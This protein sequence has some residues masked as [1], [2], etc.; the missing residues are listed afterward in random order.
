M[1][2]PKATKRAGTSSQPSLKASF[3]AVRNAKGAVS[4]RKK[5]ET[6]TPI[7]TDVVATPPVKEAVP[8][9]AP[10]KSL[11]KRHSTTDEDSEEEEDYEPISPTLDLDGD[12]KSGDDVVEVSISSWTVE[13]AS[14]KYKSMSPGHDPRREAPIGW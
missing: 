2:P 11:K 10:K 9:A 3:A 1:P 6:V 5:V 12:G 8:N 14:I 4:S 7:V 13:T